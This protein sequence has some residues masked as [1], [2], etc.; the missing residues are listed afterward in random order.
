MKPFLN[1]EFCK[2]SWNEWFRHWLR[3]SKKSSN[4]R[5]LIIFSKCLK[6]Y[7]LFKLLAFHA[8]SLPILKLFCLIY[9]QWTVGMNFFYFTISVI[10]RS[11]RCSRFKKRIHSNRLCN[12]NGIEGTLKYC[13]RK[14]PG[15]IRR[16]KLCWPCILRNKTLIGLMSWEIK[17]I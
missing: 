15:T 1:L 11:L 13:F 10:V 8:H 3:N 6:C 12:R 16:K 9:E 2:F 14:K 7:L 17:Y 5:I 4:C